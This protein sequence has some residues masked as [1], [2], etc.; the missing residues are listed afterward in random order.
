MAVTT[1]PNTALAA[2][3]TADVAGTAIVAANTHTI[4]PT[5]RLDKVIIRLVN[6]TATTKVFTLKAGDNPPAE[7]SGQGDLTVSLT[8]GSTTPQVAYLSGLESARFLQS[9]GTIEVTVASGT[10]GFITAFQLA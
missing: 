7:A 2:G 4:T 1:V 5:K 6:T 9:D 8:D 3:S 10:T